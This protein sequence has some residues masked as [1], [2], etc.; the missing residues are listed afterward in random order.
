MRRRRRLPKKLRSSGYSQPILLPFSLL[1]NKYKS[2]S[3]LRVFVNK[4]LKCVFCDRKGALLIKAIDRGGQWHVD[5][6]TNDLHLMTIDHIVPKSKGGK[7]NIEN[8]QPC[9]HECN[10]KK[11][12]KDNEEFKKELEANKALLD[13]TGAIPKEAS[14]M[15]S[16]V[17]RMS[18]DSNG[19]ASYAG[20]GQV[21]S[22]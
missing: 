20:Q 8:L 9:C 10:S 17:H 19:C 7:N 15:Q 4:G 11:G 14:S 18:G 6:Y 5:V 1:Y 22:G 2:H 16:K 12:C 3:R 21:S 13:S